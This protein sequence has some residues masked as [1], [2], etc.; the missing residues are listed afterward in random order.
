[1]EGF[2]GFSLGPFCGFSLGFISSQ[3]EGAGVPGQAAPRF[4]RLKVLVE[5]TYFAHTRYILLP[6]IDNP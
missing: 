3:W 5:V 4:D 1:M 6:Y 2:S